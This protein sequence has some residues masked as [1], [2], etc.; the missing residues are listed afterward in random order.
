MKHAMAL[1]LAC[2][3]ALA[4]CGKGN[5][6]SGL[7]EE[8]LQKHCQTAMQ[9]QDY[10]KARTFVDEMVRRQP[11]DLDALAT[12]GIVF[13]FA[14]QFADAERDFQ[15]CISIDEKKGKHARFFAADR[16]LWRSRE[17]SMKGDNKAAITLLDG[18]LTMYPESG[19]AYH[20]RGGAKIDTG[21]YN[22]A[23]T[24][25]T[26]A[27]DHDSGNNRFGDSYELRARA[28]EALGDKD[29]AQKDRDLASEKM[30]KSE[31]GGAYVSPAAG[32][33]SAHP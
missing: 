24:D 2:A 23:I 10:A 9:A 8:E 1:V 19:M 11:N 30:H 32:D 3:V 20:E 14:S 7:S 16:V 5:P 28:K 18:V 4:G 15:S 33:P 26:K 17:L 12:R 25:L 6:L 27:I 22:G 21:D 13:A 31:P 29:G